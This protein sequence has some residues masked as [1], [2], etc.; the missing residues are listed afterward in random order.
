MSR[1]VRSS[2]ARHSNR[3]TKIRTSLQYIVCYFFVDNKY[4][5]SLTFGFAFCSL[6]A[7]SHI[8]GLNRETSFFFLSKSK[9]SL[10]AKLKVFFTC[11]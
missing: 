7:K 11:F 3:L 5:F 8:K 6:K 1:L 4:V 10:S 2:G 9:L